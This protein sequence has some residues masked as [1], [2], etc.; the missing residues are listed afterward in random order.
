MCL[1]APARQL[2]E[3]NP[4]AAQWSA[5]S[6]A[7][8]SRPGSVGSI[9]FLRGRCLVELSEISSL[10]TIKTKGNQAPSRSLGDFLFPFS[11]LTTLSLNPTTSCLDDT[12]SSKPTLSYQPIYAYQPGALLPN[13]FFQ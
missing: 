4:H 1:N 13:A 7:H 6:Q 10:Q 11:S 2:T 3:Q 8:R 5:P 9:G 12:A